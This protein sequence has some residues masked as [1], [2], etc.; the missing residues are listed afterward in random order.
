MQSLIWETI[1]IVLI[2]HLLVLDNFISVD[3]IFPTKKERGFFCVRFDFI[4][5]PIRK[6]QLFAF[7]GCF[8]H[9]V[10]VGFD[11]PFPV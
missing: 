7:R 11:F 8:G 3:G 5:P 10:I 9:Q 4:W 2:S 1:M 6:G